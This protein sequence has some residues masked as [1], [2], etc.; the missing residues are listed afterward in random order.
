MKAKYNEEAALRGS[1]WSALKEELKDD[2]ERFNEIVGELARS[3][4]TQLSLLFDDLNRTRNIH[5]KYQSPGVMKK[6]VDK[7]KYTHPE[8]WEKRLNQQYY[9]QHVQP[10]VKDSIYDGWHRSSRE[11]RQSLERKYLDWVERLYWK[12]RI[13]HERFTLLDEEREELEK[14]RFKVFDLKL[15]ESRPIHVKDWQKNYVAVFADRV[16]ESRRRI[17]IY[18]YVEDYPEKHDKL[19]YYYRVHGRLYREIEVR[20]RAKKK[21]SILYS[22]LLALPLRTGS[23]NINTKEDVIDEFIRLCSIPLFIHL[24]RCLSEGLITPRQSLRGLSKVD[25]LINPGFHL[26][27]KCSR[28]YQHCIIDSAI[29]TELYRYNL[30]GHC[31]PD[32]LHHQIVTEQSEAYMIAMNEFKSLFKESKEVEE[33]KDELISLNDLSVFRESLARLHGAEDTTNSNRLR[34][35]AKI[36]ELLDEGHQE[37]YEYYH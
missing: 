16:Q 25:K 11:N 27:G 21:P 6:V 37:E 4:K 12:Y 10:G 22:R 29:F 7:M 3:R 9:T 2:E 24:T 8:D 17:V 23:R 31:Y 5:K 20:L 14:D 30:H 36:L 19:T 33:E 13:P 1:I 32:V 28:S 26:I 15:D 34:T 35:K 18:D